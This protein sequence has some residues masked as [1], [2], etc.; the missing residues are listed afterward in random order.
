MNGSLVEGGIMKVGVIGCGGMGLHHAGVLREL[1]I[2]DE[3]VCC[4]ITERCRK[5]AEEKG[6][7]VVDSVASL[8][9]DSI[10][11]LS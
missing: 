9:A 4:D 2:V 10:T 1:D 8:L 5:A 7:R 3:V 11:A 6:F